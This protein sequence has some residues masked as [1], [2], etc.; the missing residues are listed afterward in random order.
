[1][2]NEERV[3]HMTKLAFYETKG[4]SEDIKISFYHKKD[5]IGF[6]TFWS[7]LWLTI[8]YVVLVLFVGITFMGDILE[9]M[10]RTQI[11]AIIVS[12]FGLYLILLIAYTATA[13]SI[14][15]RKHARAY[16]RVKKFKEELE[17]LETMYDKEDGNE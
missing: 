10:T 14:Y 12:I 1:M 9:A 4:G 2:L 6:N 3:K 16:H 8:A 5:Y 15:K 11:I 7:G 17:E 13:K